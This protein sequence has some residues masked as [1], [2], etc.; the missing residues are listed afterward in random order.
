MP[1]AA[2]PVKPISQTS[3]GVG[4]AADGLH[5]PGPDYSAATA[6][7]GDKLRTAPAGS[8]HCSQG[9]EGCWLQ[10]AAGP[11]HAEGYE[12]KG[13]NLNFSR[14]SIGLMSKTKN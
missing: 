5:H 10:P 11:G 6:A 2:G 1:L 4:G 3:S 9:A 7:G 13:R 14:P 12:T 8:V